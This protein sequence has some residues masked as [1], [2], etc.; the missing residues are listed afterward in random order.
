[1]SRQDWRTPPWLFAMLD[2][3][4]GPF[5]MDAAASE[6]NTLCS[7][8]STD[9]LNDPWLNPTFCNPPFRNFG[10]WMRKAHSEF[11]CRRVRSCLIGPVGCSQSWFHKYAQD[12]VVLAPTKRICF[13]LPDSTYP[14]DEKTGKPTGADRDTMIYL[15]GY[16]SVEYGREFVVMPLRVDESA[17]GL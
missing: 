15:F 14:V 1:V 5:A 12:V 2:R 4:Y 10:D 3:M 8:F 16:R 9:G 6:E 11:S 7:F 13:L 17:E